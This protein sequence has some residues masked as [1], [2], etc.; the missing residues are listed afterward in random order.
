MKSTT[1]MQNR[2]S[3]EAESPFYDKRMN[4]ARN[5]ST[6]ALDE[7]FT[8]LAQRLLL[9]KDGGSPSSIVFAGIGEPNSSAVVCG[10]VAVALAD[11]TT[12]SICIVDADRTER[13]LFQLFGV[14]SDYGEQPSGAS[15]HQV[16][17]RLH[18]NLWIAGPAELGWA[19]APPMPEDVATT[20]SMLRR[21]FDYLFI[22]AGDAVSDL[23]AASV[24]QSV[25]GLVLVLK[26][27]ATRR[28]LARNVAQVMKAGGVVV[29]GAVLHNDR[30]FARAA[31]K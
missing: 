4:G 8:R 30:L 18:D 29:L 17:I 3:S 27:N 2:A 21:E 19:A 15:I 10:S 1:R 24:G 6:R 9:A 13:K 7:G 12:K 26:R 25:D 23:T 16:C 22:N 31:P 11:A 5:G 14:D 28:A 20:I